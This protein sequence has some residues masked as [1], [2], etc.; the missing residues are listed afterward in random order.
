MTLESACDNGEH[1]DLANGQQLMSSSSHLFPSPP[2]MPCGKGVWMEQKGQ[3]GG[4]M[5]VFC[6]VLKVVSRLP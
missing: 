2:C 6:K 5:W 3:V 4:F 1:G